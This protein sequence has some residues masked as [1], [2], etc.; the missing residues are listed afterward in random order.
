MN[1]IKNIIESTKGL[2]YNFDMKDW[3]KMDFSLIYENIKN[4]CDSLSIFL[5][6]EKDN[7]KEYF[8][9]FLK[10]TIKL[11][12]NNLLK[13]IML[14]Y[15]NVFFERIIKYNENFKITSLYNTL[16]YIMISTLAYYRS[17]YGSSGKI[18][19]LTKDIKLKIYSLNVLDKIAQKK[20][21]EVLNL[22]NK[23]VKEFII[24]S[25]DYFAEKYI[26]LFESDVSIEKSFTEI[27]R[28]EILDNVIE[29]KDVFKDDFLSIMNEYFE[30]KLITIYT[31]TLNEE[32][33]NFVAFVEELREGLKANIDDIFSLEPD[34]VLN[35]INNKMSTTLA[36]L[37]KYN[38][39]SNTFKISENLEN[40]L[41]NY[42]SDN[43][44]P[45][46]T[47][48]LN[49]FNEAAKNGIEDT[50]EKNADNYINY[51]SIEEFSEIADNI[52][53]NIYQNYFGKINQSI[54]NYGIEE[55]PKKLENE[56]SRQAELY[57]KKNRRILS[58]E[59]IENI[60]KEK[61]ADKTIDEALKK[62]LLSSLS[63]KTFINSF[64]KFDEFEK[65]IDEN[66]IK[67]NISYKQALKIIKDN[68]YPEEIYNNLTSIITKLK[69]STLDYYNSIKFTYNELKN[70]L[71]ES[72]NR[73]N[74]DLNKCANRTYIIFGQKYENYT[75]MK[76]IGSINNEN[77]G[78]I[79]GSEIIENQ[80][81]I[82][83]VNYTISNIQKDTQFIFK[84][85][86]EEGEIIKQIVKAKIINK[87][88]PGILKLTFINEREDEG[89]VIERIEAEFKNVNFTMDMF[90]TTGSKI[91]NVTTSANFE[92]FNY[93]KDL[94]QLIPEEK[95]VCEYIEI[96]GFEYKYC[97]TVLHYSED[98]YKELEAKKEITVESKNAVDKG[99][100]PENMIF[101]L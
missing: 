67:L 22:L 33:K 97:Y 52:H 101:E 95:D 46:F 34:E 91:L 23:N 77:I 14:T 63:A 55:Y 87:S 20:N 51:H 11:N 39:N 38:N 8:D 6:S 62:I 75:N 54:Y 4:N 83:T 29:L 10:D 7:E 26:E 12:F 31:K 5:Y 82:T 17:L 72:I 84:V 2:N 69:N 42:G 92:S 79:S 44:Q 56:I 9:I 80:A 100:V 98:N 43:I 32:T 45:K 90:L 48:I 71:K 86:Y 47:R 89:D 88:K 15:S 93:Y 24:D 58:E 59:E 61:I 37:D 13:N 57:E 94:I 41:Y 50:V 27:V 49:I 30:D 70:Y 18:K 85:D 35:D 74:K 53:K 19:A 68:N 36:S 76:N 73:I 28:Q 25:K 21:N 16:K 60:K 96:F 65:T 3:K 99:F 78:D 1:N 81:K 66:I 40:F 64:G